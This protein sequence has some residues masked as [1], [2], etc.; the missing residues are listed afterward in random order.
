M[1][2]KL[3]CIF[4]G[5]LSALSTNYGVQDWSISHKNDD[6]KMGIAG[7]FCWECIPRFN[8]LN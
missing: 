7:Y 2:K 4:G 3:E 6:K 5:I 8:A 1:S